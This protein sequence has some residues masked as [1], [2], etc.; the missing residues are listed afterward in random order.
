M[1]VPP[2]PEPVTSP[3]VVVNNSAGNQGDPHVSGDL[4]S[5][6]AGSLET[7]IRY[8][9]FSTGIDSPIPL[10]VS[11]TALL[12]DV[13]NGR[14]SFTRVTAER[15]AILVFNTAD[16]SLTEIAPQSGSSRFGS[17]LGNNTV[18][19]VDMGTGTM[20][21]DIFVADYTAPATAHALSTSP[22]MEDN[23]NVSP[24]GNIVVWELCPT[25]ETCDVMKATRNANPDF[26]FRYDASLEGYVFNL[27][28]KCQGGACFTTGTYDLNFRAGDDPALHSAAFAVR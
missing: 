19:F 5:Y 14:I 25:L 3:V 20:T 28:L 22:S 17:A 8:Y 12:S 15:T 21:G 13:N 18:A 16:A 10:G 23:P 26:D 2:S 4:V 6:S 1:L 11:P 24:D 7:S 9:R 27:S